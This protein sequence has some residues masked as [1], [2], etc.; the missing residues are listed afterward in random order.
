MDWHDHVRTGG[1][2]RGDLAGGQSAVV[3][4]EFIYRP[5][6]EGVAGVH[7]SPHEIMDIV[8]C[9][10]RFGEGARTCRHAIQVKGAKVLLSRVNNS[11]D[12]PHTR[13]VQRANGATQIHEFFT[14]DAGALDR[15][16]SGG[17]VPRVRAD[18]EVGVTASATVVIAEIENTRPDSVNIQIDPC[19][20][21]HRLIAVN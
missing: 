17:G 11:H 19:F 14:R 7:G 4:A 16:A 1:E 20:D 8:D 9:A 6:Q 18:E 21:G 3:N 15:Q 10:Q 5:I 2:V 12:V 13:A